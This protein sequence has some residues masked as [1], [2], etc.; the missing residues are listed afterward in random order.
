MIKIAIEGL[1]GSGKSSIA[2]YISKIY[3]FEYKNN[4]LENMLNFDDSDFYRMKNKL[5]DNNNIARTMIFMSSLIY[6]F[7]NCN[8]NTVFD[9]YILSEYYYDGSKET[10]S[11]FDYFMSFNL[12]PDLTILLYASDDV[13]FKRIIKRDSNDPDLNKINNGNMLYKKM[14]NFIKKYNINS[15]IIDTDNLSIEQIITII[16]ENIENLLSKKRNII[17]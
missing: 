10:D 7:K 1:D 15:L 17:K 13:R 12:I 6:S 5:D 2:K 4:Y 9:R 16:D 3:N 11:L 14:F 8:S